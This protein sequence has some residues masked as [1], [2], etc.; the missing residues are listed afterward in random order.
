MVKLENIFEGSK[1]NLERESVKK[2]ISGGEIIRLESVVSPRSNTPSGV[3]DHNEDEFVILLNPAFIPKIVLQ[4][5]V[6]YLPDCE[7]KYVF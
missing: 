3:Y 4:L 1:A 2:L 7:P 5:P 6:S